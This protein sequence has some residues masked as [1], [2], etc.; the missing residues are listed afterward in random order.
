M[1]DG[2]GRRRGAHALF[3]LLA[4]SPPAPLGIIRLTLLPSP[5]NYCVSTMFCPTPRRPSPKV[6]AEA[7]ERA[8][9]AAAMPNPLLSQEAAA[10]AAARA[11]YT[12]HALSV[13]RTQG[14]LRIHVKH[15]RKKGLYVFGFKD[16]SLAGEEGLVRVEVR[17]C[18]AT[19]LLLSPD[20]QL[21]GPC[22]LPLTPTLSP[23]LPLSPLP[24][25]MKFYRWTA[26]ICAARVWLPSW[27]R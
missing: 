6:L 23:S 2:S 8:R 15:S 26:L 27:P 25:R 21:Q 13:P 16:G 3:F 19:V 10:R 24:P 11:P 9:K 14:E 17:G 1:W 4:S 22:N 18:A 12:D 20:H 7:Q 5:T